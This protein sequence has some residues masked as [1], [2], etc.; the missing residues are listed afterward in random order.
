MP[1]NVRHRLLGD[2][3]RRDFDGG[4]QRR[5]V[6]RRFD[7]DMELSVYAILRGALPKREEQAKFIERRRPERV[8]QPPDIGDG[9]S[10]LCREVGQERVGDR[11][12]G[13]AV[14]RGL[15]LER[16]AGELGSETVVEITR[17][18]RSSSRAV[19]S[20]SRESCKSAASCTVRV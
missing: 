8:D 13:Q 7:R 20:C 2:P 10:G 1:R 18:R 4:G 5:E 9:G 15:Q 17:R 16:E 11:V 14:P 6:R 12:G 3:K 19:I